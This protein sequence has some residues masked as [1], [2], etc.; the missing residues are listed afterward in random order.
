MLPP[1]NGGPRAWTPRAKFLVADRGASACAPEHTL[2]AYRLA[3][4]QGADY[5]RCDLALTRDGALICLQDATLARS[6]DAADRFPDRAPWFA[7]DFTLAEI[8]SLDAGRWFGARFA[9]ARIPTF[10]DAIAVVRGRAGLFA[11][12]GHPEV[13]RARNVDGPRLLAAALRRHGLDRRGGVR[14]TPVILQ[15]P[16]EPTIRDLKARLPDVPRVLLVDA[17]AAAR[18]AD[19]DALA[20]LARWADGIG[21]AARIVACD[22]SVVA[23]AHV[24][25]LGVVVWAFDGDAIGGFPSPRAEMSFFLD[26]LD[27]DGVITSCPDQFPRPARRDRCAPIARRA[28]R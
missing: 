10:D 6:T 11:G 22:P 12:L 27:V 18:V 13:Y 8:A 2:A 20:A 5:I 9:G 21:P 4:E 15:T 7:A 1:G 16:H 14:G 3:I 26:T 24:Q 17:A 23:R 28:G 25:G 19:A